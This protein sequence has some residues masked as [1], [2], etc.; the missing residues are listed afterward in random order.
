MAQERC[1]FELI[2]SS[3]GPVGV[4][5]AIPAPIVAASPYVAGINF[6]GDTEV[7]KPFM[8]ANTEAKIITPPVNATCSD[9][10]DPV[11]VDWPEMGIN[12]VKIEFIGLDPATGGIGKTTSKYTLGVFAVGS[13]PRIGSKQG[14][15]LT[16]GE[17]YRSGDSVF[18]ADFE[19]RLANKAV[20][21]IVSFHMKD[22]GVCEYRIDTVFPNVHKYL[23]EDGS[24]SMTSAYEA[25]V[26]QHDLYRQGGPP[27]IYMDGC[28]GPADPEH[29]TSRDIGVAV[30]HLRT[31]QNP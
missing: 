27:G 4:A 1:F 28:T 29:H 31:E 23:P 30:G 7:P 24:N 6:D 18:P 2:T 19:V 14:N 9:A 3:S 13:A 26:T 25:L 11:T 20:N 10:T 17:R 8:P 15:V 12:G 16:G 22:G 5:D 21:S